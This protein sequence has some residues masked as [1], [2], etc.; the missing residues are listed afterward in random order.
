MGCLCP[1]RGHGIDRVVREKRGPSKR[2]IKSELLLSG[3]E[4]LW[5]R[6]GGRAVAGGTAGETR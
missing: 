4:L 6:F 3:V 1:A 2:E 5:S